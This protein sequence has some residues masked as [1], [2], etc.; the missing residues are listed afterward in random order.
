MILGIETATSIC[1]VGLATPERVLAEISFDIKNIHDHAL[2]E[3]IAQLLRLA[4]LHVQDLQAIAVS[5]GP[6]SF[7]GLRIGMSVAKGMAFTHNKPMVAVSTLLLQAAA[8]AAHAEAFATANA[9]QACPIVSVLAS[10]RH[11]IYAASFRRAAPLPELLSTAQVMRAVDFPSS[12]S[13]RAVL[14]GNGLVA[15]REAGVLAQLQRHYLV[16]PENARLSGGW[17]ARLGQ[18]KWAR[19]EVTS[20]ENLEPFYIQDFETGPVAR[21]I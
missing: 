17:A 2:T 13:E 7:T 10:R 9:L 12:L 11:E 20:A 3:S 8:A 18:I 1:S 6:G 14:C 21:R 19:G 5:A 15:L 16:A 4:K